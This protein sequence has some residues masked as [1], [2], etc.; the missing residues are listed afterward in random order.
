MKEFDGI[1]DSNSFLYPWKL[2]IL[3]RRL[4]IMTLLEPDY[5]IRLSKQDDI[6]DGNTHGSAE[7]T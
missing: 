5:Y 1:V 3:A 4:L 2:V 6:E 7:H